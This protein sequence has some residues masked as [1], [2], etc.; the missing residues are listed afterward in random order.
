M[1]KQTFTIAALSI[2]LAGSLVSSAK[3]A[4]QDFV[5]NWVNVNSNTSGITRFVITKQGQDLRIQV[6]G[7]CHPTDCDWGLAPLVTYGRNVQDPNHTAATTTYAPS[8]ARNILTLNLRG[9]GNNQIVLQNF[10]QFVDNSNRQNYFT[11]E[12]FRQVALTP[13]LVF[14]GTEAY[15]ANGKQWIRYKLAIAN[16]EI[17]PAELFASAPDLPPCGSNTNASRTWVDIFNTAT[18]QRI[19]GFCAL[20]SPQDLDSLWFAVERGTAP[21]QQVY[22]VLTDRKTSTSYRSNSV[23]LR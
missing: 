19:Y 15:T 17:F 14:K 22:V 2:A 21:P 13:R 1:L 3:A 7:K 9:A 12:S 6:F 16:K 23:T 20:S 5:G 18:N 4:P 11:Q 10:T 8:F